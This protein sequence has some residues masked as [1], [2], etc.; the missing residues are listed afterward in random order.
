MRRTTNVYDVRFDYLDNEWE[1]IARWEILA[2]GP[3]EAGMIARD[4]VY[5]EGYIQRSTIWV[6]L[7]SQVSIH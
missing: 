6:R 4:R 7:T 5:R 1:R 3:V 2:S